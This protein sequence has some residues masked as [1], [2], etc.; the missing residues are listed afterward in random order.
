MPPA[1]EIARSNG[2][3]PAKRTGTAL[4]KAASVLESIVDRF[5]PSAIAAS[6]TKPMATGERPAALRK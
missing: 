4:M 2:A 3:T 1:V 5:R 6:C